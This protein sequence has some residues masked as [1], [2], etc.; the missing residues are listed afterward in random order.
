MTFVFA[1]DPRNP[2]PATAHHVAACMLTALGRRK[3]QF[4]VIATAPTHDVEVLPNA[5]VVVP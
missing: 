5:A 2:E 3:A 1:F 4:A